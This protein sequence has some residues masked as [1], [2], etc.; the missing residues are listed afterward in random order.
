MFKLKSKST[1]SKIGL[2]FLEYDSDDDI[3]LESQNVEEEQKAEVEDNG[4]ME[5]T[6]WLG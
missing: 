2:G 6:T 1:D 5:Q 4:N 3:P